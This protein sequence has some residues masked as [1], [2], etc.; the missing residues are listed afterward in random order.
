MRT[1]LLIFFFFFFFFF[2]FCIKNY[3]GIQGKVFTVKDL[4]IRPPPL[5]EM[6][7]SDRSKALVPMLFLFCVA[8][9]FTLRGAS[10]LVLH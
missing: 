8:L 9:Q 1:E 10:C 2:F 3:I 7:T 4:Y 6:Y 5:P